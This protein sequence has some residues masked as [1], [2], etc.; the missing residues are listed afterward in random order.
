MLS[1]GCRYYCFCG[2]NVVPIGP[3]PVIGRMTFWHN[4]GEPRGGEH[5]I[6]MPPTLCCSFAMPLSRPEYLA[7]NLTRPIPTKDR[8]VL[9]TVAD[10]RDYM[11]WLPEDREFQHHWQQM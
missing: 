7:T 6:R 1:T 3:M 8:G 5:V 9:R 2:I 4:A 10:A 11:A